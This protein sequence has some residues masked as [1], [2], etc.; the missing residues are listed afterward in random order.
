MYVCM[1]VC[2]YAHMY[3][4]QAV[5]SRDVL[6]SF[7]PQALA[8]AADKS[9]KALVGAAPRSSMHDSDD[10]ATSAWAHDEDADAV[11]GLAFSP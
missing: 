5:K 7:E 3:I 8:F 1:Y 9:I 4:A 11:A 10:V 6:P 2:M